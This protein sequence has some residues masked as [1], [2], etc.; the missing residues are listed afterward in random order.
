MGE[1]NDPNLSFLA[2][3]AIDLP[4]NV[5]FDSF[6]RFVDELPNPST[7]SYLEMDLRLAWSPLKDLELA[8]VGR[9]LLHDSHAEFAGATITRE[10]PRSVYGTLRWSF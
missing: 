3:S 7:P 6:L 4:C 10:V 9:N 5:Q 1:A 2:H 8:I